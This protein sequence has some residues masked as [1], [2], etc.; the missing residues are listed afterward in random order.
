MNLSLLRR[1][2][3]LPSAL[4]VALAASACAPVPSA[5]SSGTPAADDHG[6]GAAGAVEVASPARALVIADEHGEATLL[7][8][9][10]E[11]RRT[12]AAAEA[13]VTAVTGDGRL[14]FRTRGSGAAAA[15]EVIDTARWTVPHGDHTHSFRGEPRLLGTLAGAGATHAGS[16]GQRTALGLDDGEVVVLVHDEL[17]DG[18]DRAPRLD[19]PHAGPVLPFADHLLVPTADGTIRVVDADGVPDSTTAL[20]CTA[21]I[22]ESG[23]ALTDPV[24]AD[25]GA[26]VADADALTD[27]VA[28]DAGAPVADADALTDPV[29][30]DASAP[31]ADAAGLTPDPALTSALT[32]GLAAAAGPDVAA[33]DADMTRVGAV[34]ACRD[35]AVLFTR[36]VGGTVVG[37]SILAPPGSTMPGRLSGRTDRPDL[38]G[39]AVD[40]TAWLLDVRQRAWTALPSQTPL[41]R[42]AALGDDD[43]RTVVIDV[44][45]RVRVLAPDGEVL[46]RSEPVLADA[47]ADPALRDRI[48]LL[49]DATHAYVTDPAAG[50]VHEIDVDDGRTIRTFDELDPRF[51]QLV[52]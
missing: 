26:P 29:A 17:G 28:A 35:G 30:A 33:L 52:G 14:V 47:V 11:E 25:A 5:V 12:L 42:A 3:L 34:Y 51:V 4:A 49:I 19:L 48:H 38:A 21:G 45:G 2:A 50:A 18:V 39:V 13:D 9:D 6:V 24:A 31:V 22:A 37:E 36:A 41:V 20:L 15:V 8:L 32:S 44:E 27:P 46:A 40:G 16:A 7:D 23:G 10:T 1:A 43:S